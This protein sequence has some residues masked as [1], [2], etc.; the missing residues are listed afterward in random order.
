MHTFLSIFKYRLQV[1]RLHQ[2]VIIY[3]DLLRLRESGVVVFWR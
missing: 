2:L 1:I 3:G